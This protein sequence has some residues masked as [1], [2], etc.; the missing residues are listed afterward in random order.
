MNSS[1]LDVVVQATSRS[2]QAEVLLDRFA[3]AFANFD[4]AMIAE[5]FATPSVALRKDGTIVSLA[6]RED[7]LRYYQA[8]LDS[9][10]RDGCSSCRW[11]ELEVTPM[12]RRSMLATVTWYLL[13]EDG[14][15]ST[16]WRQSYTLSYSETGPKIFASA[17]HVE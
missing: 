3:K 5:L 12:G 17:M 16:R 6:V 11:E 9:Y 8:A 10:R 13:R 7:V 15:V 4:A 14:S 2:T 1:N